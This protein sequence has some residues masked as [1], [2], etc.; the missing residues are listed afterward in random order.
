MEMRLAR[1]ARAFAGQCRPAFGAEPARRPAGRRLEFADLALGDAISRAL[2]IDED[3]NRRATV[4]PAA[5]AMAPVNALRRAMSDKADR[6]AQAAALELLASIAHDPLRFVSDT[7]GLVAARYSTGTKI[8]WRILPS[9]AFDRCP[10]PEVSST[11]ITS[12]APMIRA[13]PSLAV[14]RTPASRLMMYCR[15]GAGCQSRS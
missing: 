15:R 5:L 7:T 4:L 8:Q 10:L 12:P 6:T 9:T 11:R 13:S 14:I 2:E 3:R 1:Q